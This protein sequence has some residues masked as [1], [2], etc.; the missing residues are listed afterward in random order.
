MNDIKKK[1]HPKEAVHGT[2]QL[3][4]MPGNLQ[5]SEAQCQ[6]AGYF[7]AKYPRHAR[8]RTMTTFTKCKADGSGCVTFYQEP[9][10]IAKMQ[11]VRKFDTAKLAEIRKVLIEIKGELLQRKQNEIQKQEMAA[12]LRDPNRLA[13]LSAP[14]IEEMF[15]RDE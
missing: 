13:K 15:P 5:I 9:A 2:K 14:E 10:R 7:K 11:P 12:I 4:D 1:E 8:R 3:I 6:G